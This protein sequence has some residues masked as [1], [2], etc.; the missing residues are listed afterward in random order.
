MPN[1]ALCLGTVREL[2]LVLAEA[3]LLSKRSNCQILVLNTEKLSPEEEMVQAL[4]TITHCFSTRL[5]G[6]RNYRKDLK[7]ALKT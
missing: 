2:P 3:F 4:M 6:L 5:Y 7:K 1:T